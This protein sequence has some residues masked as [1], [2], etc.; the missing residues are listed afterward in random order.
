M[1]VGGG[2][3]GKGREAVA[4]NPFMIHTANWRHING[5]EAITSR[6]FLQF[7]LLPFLWVLRMNIGIDFSEMQH[8]EQAI[9]S[10]RCPSANLSTNAHI[11]QSTASY[12]N[13]GTA[14]ILDVYHRSLYPPIGNMA[15]L[16]IAMMNSLF[17]AKWSTVDDV[18]S[19]NFAYAPAYLCVIIIIRLLP[20][21]WASNQVFE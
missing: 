2:G 15:I 1:C 12:P 9:Q 14:S 21:N 4:Y 19:I 10:F 5:G 13:V 7:Q 8:T 17:G 18:S 6:E 20:S 11:Y 16:C 3:W